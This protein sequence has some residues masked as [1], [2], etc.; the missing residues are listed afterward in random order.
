VHG[1]HDTDVLV[2]VVAVAPRTG[3]VIKHGL[4]IF[5]RRE[6]LLRNGI[7]HFV[8]KFRQLLE[9]VLESYF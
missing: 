6:D 4:N 5:E 9:I 3:K 1:R 2:D 8:F 7:L